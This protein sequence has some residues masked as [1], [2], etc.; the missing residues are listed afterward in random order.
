MKHQDYMALAINLAKAAEGQ[1]SPNPQVGAVL[2]KDGE[3]IGFGAHLRAGEP[4]AE[5]HA[6]T[7]AGEKV[8]GANLYVTLEPC[9][10]VG[11]TPPCSNLVIKSGIKKVFVASV[12]PNPLVAGAGITKMREAGIEVEV[13]LLAEEAIALNNVFFHYIST[14]LPFVTLKSATS[15][16][17]KIAT[18]SGESK[19]ITGEEARKDVHHF[20]HTQDAILVGVNTVIKD[21]PSLTTRLETGGKNPVRVILDSTLRTPMESEV[22]RDH[23]AETIIVTAAGA[24]PER[25]K[26]FEDQGIKIIKLET[27]KVEINEMLKKLGERGITSLFVEGGAEVHGSFLK[28]KAFQQVITYIAPKLIG[29][30]NAPT[31]YGGE[32]IVRLEETVP[33]KITDVKQIGEDIRIIA[34]PI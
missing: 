22:I 8:K 21:N 12:D 13:G 20:R 31:A 24:K 5:V 27:A 26:Q 3:I 10:H 28:E 7:M 25:A 33:L 30:R 2:V 23:A 18:V 6:I 32:G 11:K 29:G 16:D 4:H 19:W 17:G 34:E 15:L 14:G 1:T 9:S